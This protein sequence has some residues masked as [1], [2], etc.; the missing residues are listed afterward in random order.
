MRTRALLLSILAVFLM[1]QDRWPSSTAGGGSGNGIVGTTAT[2]TT[3]NLL[4]NLTHFQGPGIASLPRIYVSCAAGGDFPAGDDTNPGTKTLPIKT[5]ELVQTVV[6]ASSRIHVIF[7]AGDTWINDG[8]PALS[9]CWYNNGISTANFDEIDSATL[10]QGGIE[11]AGNCNDMDAFCILVSGSDFTG[12]TKPTFDCTDLYFSASIF[13]AN[14]STGW[15]GFQNLH[16]TNCPDVDLNQMIVN[17]ATL[18]TAD[19]VPVGPCSGVGTSVGI[20]TG[21][22]VTRGDVDS[23]A[24]WLN[25]IVDDVIYQSNQAF[26]SH[27]SAETV[28]INFRGTAIDDGQDGNGACTANDAPDPCCTGLDA[29]LCASAQPFAPVD[30]TATIDLFG[31]W[32]QQDTSDEPLNVIGV[33]TSSG[34]GTKDGEADITM[35]FFGFGGWYQTN[36]VATASGA[37]PFITGFNNNDDIVNITLIRTTILG[38]PVNAGEA[39]L[40]LAP[41][42]GSTGNIMTVDLVQTTV[43]EQAHLFVIGAANAADTVTVTA[44]CLLMDGTTNIDANERFMF[45]VEG[46]SAQHVNT[47]VSITNSFA[48]EGEGGGTRANFSLFGIDYDLNSEVPWPATWT[49][50]TDAASILGANTDVFRPIPK[51]NALCP[52]DRDCHETCDL[53]FTRALPFTIIAD[54]IG[55]PITHIRFG[56]LNR[57]MGAR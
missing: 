27:D 47:T 36:L 4:Q 54:V 52:L 33:R 51:G 50:L 56:G 22:D 23:H 48:D 39:S 37:S 46:T 18:C 45:S 8:D 11:L 24:I 3:M 1:G 13:K 55:D 9:D 7:D 40:K 49:V 10:S 12:R 20:L 41:T 15:V 34:T 30:N 42:E 38:V 35:D 43:T 2:E 57:N 21:H 53:V 5:M 14:A 29:G 17:D 28:L 25:I 19:D 32:L 44:S 16:F 26:T 31:T 6:S